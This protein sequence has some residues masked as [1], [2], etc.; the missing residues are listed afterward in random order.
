MRLQE[1]P[2]ARIV[3][4]TTCKGDMLAARALKAEETVKTYMKSILS[5][6]HASDRSHAVAIAIE[7]G[8][9]DF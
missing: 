9:L 6:L 7:R 5:K 8:F 1:V 2:N 4:L 3:V